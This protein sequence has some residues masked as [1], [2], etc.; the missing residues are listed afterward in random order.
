MYW[1]I[2]NSDVIVGILALITVFVLIAI[3]FL[4][5]SR[6]KQIEKVKEWLLYACVEAEK[7]LGNK[8]GE[9]KLRYVYDMFVDKFKF[10]SMFLSFEDFSDLVD[11]SLNTVEDM[12]DTNKNLKDYI[13]NK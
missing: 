5:I 3:K 12:L 7:S 4:Q 1:L 10:V 8:T 11:D 13:D 2:N 9:I 6:D